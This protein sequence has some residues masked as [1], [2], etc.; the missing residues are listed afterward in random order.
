MG[1]RC[2][3]GRDSALKA[4]DKLAVQA[5]LDLYRRSRVTTMVLRGKQLQGVL[6]IA[7]R[8][9]FGD[10]TPVLDAQRARQVQVS[11]QRPIGGPWL[12]RRDAEAGVEMG[13]ECGQHPPRS[14]PQRSRP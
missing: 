7:H 4:H 5:F 1:R 9:I 2:A 6:L 13:Q 11:A 12:R 3:A 8:V 14:L 10:A